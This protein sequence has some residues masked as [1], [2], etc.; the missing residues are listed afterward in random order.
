MACTEAGEGGTYTARGSYDPDVFVTEFGEAG[1]E[2][3]GEMNNDEGQE[4]EKWKEVGN[5]EHDGTLRWRLKRG[6]SKQRTV[7]DTSECTLFRTS[8]QEFKKLL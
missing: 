2:E 7:R 4:E 3:R 8:I 5:R 1:S 6:R